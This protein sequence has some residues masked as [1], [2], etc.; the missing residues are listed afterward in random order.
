MLFQ[1]SST[2]LASLYVKPYNYF[3][4]LPVLLCLSVI[5]LLPFLSESL[6]TTVCQVQKT[7]LCSQLRGLSDS[8][9]LALPPALLVP[10]TSPSWF[11]PLTAVPWVP[12]LGLYLL[13]HF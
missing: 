11:S 4:S 5:P 13:L 1:V 3:P 2:L 8:H 9:H 7:L 6:M 12:V 10:S